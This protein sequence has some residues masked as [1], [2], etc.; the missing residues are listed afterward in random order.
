MSQ[1]CAL[2]C[3]KPV[4]VTAAVKQMYWSKKVVKYK[5]KVGEQFLSTVLEKMYTVTFHHC[6]PRMFFF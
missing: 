5:Y 1:S 4:F 3:I 2:V 6:L